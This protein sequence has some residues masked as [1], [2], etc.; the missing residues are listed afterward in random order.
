MYAEVKG[1]ADLIKH[2]IKPPMQPISVGGPFHRV[3][4]C[5]PATSDRVWKSVCG[6]LSRLLH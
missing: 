1:T 2:L 3:S 6:D 4:R 5:P